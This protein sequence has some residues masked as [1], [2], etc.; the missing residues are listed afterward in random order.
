MKI[1]FITSFNQSYYDMYGKYLVNS[2]VKYFPTTIPLYVYNEDLILPH[3]EKNIISMEFNLGDNY[4]EF[5][6]RN[7]KSRIKIFA[8][9]AFS[10]LHACKNIDADRIIWIDSDCQVI[11]RVPISFLESICP[12]DKL[13]AHMGIWYYDKKTREGNVKLNTPIY[14]PETGFNVINKNHKLFN[15]FI[16]RYEDYYVSDKGVKLRRFYDNDVFGAVVKSF[17][18]ENF[19]E[20][21]PDYHKTPMRRT[22]L[23]KYFEHY[24]GKVKRQENF[25]IKEK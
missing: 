13:T 16:E 15:N 10:W 20:L 8:K 17:P 11:Q 7:H 23:G 18:E 12:D 5:I 9:K 1:A 21:N 14:C 2:F 6:R 19:V 24:K 4:Q 3:T 22:I 25:L